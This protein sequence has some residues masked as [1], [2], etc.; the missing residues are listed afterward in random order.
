MKI[1][2]NNIRLVVC[3]IDGTLTH[4]K[5]IIPSAYTIEILEK[6][7]EKGILFGLASGRGVEQ[8]RDL[9]TDWGLS[10]D[11]DLVI[12]LNGSE[13]YDL[14]SEQKTQLF[15]L[16][17]MDIKE[18]ITGMLKEF[19]D[20]NCSIYR[21]N[22][23][24]LRFIDEKAIDSK[25]KTNMDNYLLKD[26]SELWS[27]PCSKVMFRVTEEIMEKI[28]PLAKHLSNDRYRSTKT[29]STM[30]EFV[31]A[32]AN[33]GTALEE[34]CRNNDLDLSQVI[35]FGDMNNDIELLQ[36]AGIGVCMINGN[37]ETKASADIISDLTNNED[38]CAAFI[39]RYILNHEPYET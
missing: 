19:P 2:L 38:G 34:Y 3:D 11:F 12:G 35:S 23:R 28:E 26:L 21:N 24:I 37:D 17:E 36:V 7:H 9:K 31:H 1:Y 25:K 32:K 6:L 33:K 14:K 27:E 39:E 8:L 15:S 22:V 4:D 13:Y 18:I 10:F 29:Q 30:L 16:S 5:T 20:L